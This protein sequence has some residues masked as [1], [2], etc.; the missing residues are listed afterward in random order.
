M[1]LQSLTHSEVYGAGY[2]VIL[3]WKSDPRFNQC[4]RVNLTERPDLLQ[5]EDCL[6]VWKD[7][8]SVLVGEGESADVLNHDP[9]P[10]LNL[11]C[12]HSHAPNAED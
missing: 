2:R 3:I 1:A 12:H 6:G 11:L 7:V 4:A 8:E 10:G 5:R 9:R